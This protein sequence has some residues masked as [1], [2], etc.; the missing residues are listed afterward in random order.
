MR[1]LVCVVVQ[2]CVINER[3]LR[4]YL[5]DRTWPKARRRSP[6][7]KRYRAEEAPIPQSDPSGPTNW[8]NGKKDSPKARN[9]TTDRMPRATR[10]PA[11]F[12]WRREERR[13]LRRHP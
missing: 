13:R 5:L 6:K 1:R 3:Q 10:Y 11:T 8:H 9:G 12:D 2:K 4:I 7:P